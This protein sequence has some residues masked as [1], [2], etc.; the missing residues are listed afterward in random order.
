VDY[1]GWQLVIAAE[2]GRIDVNNQ[3]WNRFL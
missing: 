1:G 3:A 2:T